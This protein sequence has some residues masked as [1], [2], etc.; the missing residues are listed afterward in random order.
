MRILFVGDIVGKPGKHACS[1]IIPRL[2][3]Q[4]EIDCVIANAE[5]TAAGSGITPQMFQ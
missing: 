2:V 4:R 3:R 5:N 1:Q